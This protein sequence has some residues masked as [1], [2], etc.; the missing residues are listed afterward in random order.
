MKIKAFA[1]EKVSLEQMYNVRK[2]FNGE[3][4]YKGKMPWENIEIEEIIKL[5]ETDNYMVFTKRFGEVDKE[6]IE[7]L[8]AI[9]K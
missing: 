6:D 1:V 8:K 3:G 9:E 5:I 4:N 7:K 2:S